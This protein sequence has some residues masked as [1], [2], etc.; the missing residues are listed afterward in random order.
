[1]H[2]EPKASAKPAKGAKSDE[3]SADFSD[4]FEVLSSSVAMYGKIRVC[5]APKTSDNSSG[6]SEDA[7]SIGDEVIMFTIKTKEVEHFDCSF[8]GT[9]VEVEGDRLTIQ[10]HDDRPTAPCKQ[11][12]DLTVHDVL[13]STVR[14]RKGNFD[15]VNLKVL[16][17]L[18]ELLREG[19]GHP[20]AGGVVSE[21]FEKEG[22]SLG[23]SLVPPSP[24]EERDVQD[25]EGLNEGQVEAIRNALN[26][27]VSLIHG[28]PG[29]GKTTA[30]VR[31]VEEC[32]KIGW[33]VLVTA[34]SN[35]AVDNVLE[36]LDERGVDKMVRLGHTARA[37][38]KGRGRK[39][40]LGNILDAHE[41]M[42]I[43]E[44][45][46]KEI[47]DI[48]GGMKRK[49]GAERKEGWKRVKEDRREIRDR[50]DRVVK[51][52][53]GNAKVVFATCVGARTRVME[54]E[55]FDIVVVDEAGMCLEGWA[56]AAMLKGRRAV[57]AGDHLQLPPVVKN[58]KCEELAVT[59]FERMMGRGRE[60][61]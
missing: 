28:P 56:W 34:P 35:V 7:H 48:I 15:K 9:V 6:I 49:R 42:E 4:D 43:V 57:L 17:A 31:L 61:R 51:E 41:G 12:P 26:G 38:G 47:E 45:V 20:I 1:M 29:T 60:R 32:I 39:W 14:L 44:D 55:A 2:Y 22:S 18:E 50:T 40:V 54:K 36:R 23:S 52:V 37:G 19:V 5:L 24:P 25:K 16:K 33:R 30:V 11:S 46:R 59:L 13:S 3:A 27:T 21:V 53:V 58:A 8:S 10:F